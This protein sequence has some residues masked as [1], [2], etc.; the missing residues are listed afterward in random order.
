MCRSATGGHG[1]AGSPFLRFPIVRRAGRDTA[2]CRFSQYNA[3]PDLLDGAIGRGHR[4]VHCVLR[5]L[6]PLP[7]DLAGADASAVLSRVLS[8]ICTS[9]SYSLELS[10]LSFLGIPEK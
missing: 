3:V 4:A 10:V 9:S 7:P 1:G 6:P 5:R 2:A 8:V